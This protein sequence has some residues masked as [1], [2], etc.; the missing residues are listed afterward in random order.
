MILGVVR[1]TMVSLLIP[2]GA[3]I[4]QEVEE[5]P[6]NGL[7][8]PPAEPLRFNIAK[9]TRRESGKEKVLYFTREGFKHGAS[10]RSN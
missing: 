1:P 7:A 2:G 10:P 4:L 6:R 8:Q 5:G 9:R 3:G